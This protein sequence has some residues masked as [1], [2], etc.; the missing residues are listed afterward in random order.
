MMNLIPYFELKLY[1]DNLLLNYLA[2]KLLQGKS[3]GF[4]MRGFTVKRPNPDE[5]NNLAVRGGTAT[6]DR[7]R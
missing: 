5:S 6:N 2:L 4:V 7:H 1:K 3:T